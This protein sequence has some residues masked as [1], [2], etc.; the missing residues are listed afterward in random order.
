M[1]KDDGRDFPEQMHNKNLILNCRTM[2]TFTALRL[3]HI[4]FMIG[5]LIINIWNICSRIKCRNMPNLTAIDL[6][7]TFRVRILPEEMFTARYILMRSVF[8]VIWMAFNALLLFCRI[9]EGLISN[10][11]PVIK[12]GWRCQLVSFKIGSSCI[13]AVAR[14]CPRLE[15][16]RDTSGSLSWHLNGC[17]G[18]SRGLKNVSVSALILSAETGQEAMSPLRAG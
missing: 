16:V 17:R 2:E 10:E 13:D 3:R 18:L 8:L 14:V 12:T 1:E 9:Q 15:G 6:R 11:R 4:S 5:P 7:V